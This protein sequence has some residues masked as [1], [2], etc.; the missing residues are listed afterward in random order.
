VLV[1]IS[2][3]SDIVLDV[4]RAADP[5]RSAAT[6]VR[7]TRLAEGESVSAT[8]FTA[9][10]EAKRLEPIDSDIRSPPV[11][12][13]GMRTKQRLEARTEAVKGLEQ[14][15]LQKLVES[16]LPKET[17]TLFGHGTAGGMWRSMLAQQLAEKIGCAVDLGVGKSVPRL[18]GH[19]PTE[20]AAYR[21]GDAH[22]GV[23][24]PT[25]GEA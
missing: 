19:E 15:V 20:V 1:S 9:I 21:D 25:D 11:R 8:D 2:P 17:S 13:D 23:G 14:L 4:A 7:L 16:M 6:T 3:A 18:T 22:R 24:G 5:A 10:V 12:G